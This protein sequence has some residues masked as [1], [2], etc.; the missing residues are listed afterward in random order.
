MDSE[1]LRILKAMSP[2]QK[3]NA[4]VQLICAARDLKAAALR[5]RHPDWSEE[6]IEAAVRETF[7]Y[8]RS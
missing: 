6:E 4:G 7:L 1:H 5:S 8:A 3:L 2:E